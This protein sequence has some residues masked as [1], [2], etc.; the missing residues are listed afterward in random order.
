M[1]DIHQSYFSSYS[2]EEL[3]PTL[4]TKL[5]NSQLV[6]TDQKKNQWIASEYCDRLVL[7][8]EPNFN[9]LCDILLNTRNTINLKGVSDLLNKKYPIKSRVFLYNKIKNLR[10]IDRV[11][12]VSLDY[13][14]LGIDPFLLKQNNLTISIK[15][16]NERRAL[17]KQYMALKSVSMPYWNITVDNDLGTSEWFG[18]VIRYLYHFGKRDF[19]SFYIPFELKKN[20]IVGY[21]FKLFSFLMLILIVI[22]FSI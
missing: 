12:A 22:F 19:N 20:A 14:Y 1:L 18:A 13:I 9:M 15:E 7:Y 8:P 4:R 5:I 17:E 16:K 10:Y 6:Y 21:F 2:K 3:P 11:T